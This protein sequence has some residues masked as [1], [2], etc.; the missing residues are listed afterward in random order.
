MG[1]KRW[2][3]RH[4]RCSSCNTTERR[5]RAK[6][7]CARC[8]SRAT[9]RR[10]TSPRTPGTGP[11]V[12]TQLTEAV[13]RQ[14]YVEEE[15]S[16]ITI[17]ARFGCTRQYVLYLMKLY[18]IPAR[19]LSQARRNAQRDGKVRYEMQT[20]DGPR[21]LTVRNVSMNEQFFREW[22]P[23]MAYVLGVF[24]TD[25]CITLSRTGYYTAT[26]SQKEPELLNKCLSL[27]SCDARIRRRRQAK[28]GNW[29]HIFGISIQRVCKDLINLG[30]HPRKSLTLQF[31]SVPRAVLR[32]F[33]RGC[34]DGDGSIFKLGSVPSSWR[35][36][37]VSGSTAFIAGMHDS[38]VQLGMPPAKIRCNPNPTG[39]IYE[40][41]WS[42]SRCAKLSLVLYDGVPATEY[43]VRKYVRFHA[44]ATE[45]SSASRR[46]AG[47]GGC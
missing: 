9:E 7:L 20:A 16:Q 45:V 22:T 1:P 37:F 18:G 47:T 12:F 32:D 21:W 27:M 33:I 26:I 11:P 40:I 13:L 36:K 42:G 25:G 38:L 15:Q 44:A 4:D 46:P 35:A 5:H 24:Y 3:A 10:L 39:C 30:L 43:L 34:W 28:T 6:G 41:S 19:S 2:A 14:L 23:Q 31:P 17:A 8:Y 29:L